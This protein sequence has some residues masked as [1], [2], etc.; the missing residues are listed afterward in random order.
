MRLFLPAVAVLSGAGGAVA[1]SALGALPSV[2]YAVACMTG[3]TAVAWWV[4]R[5]KRGRRALVVGGVIVSFAIHMV[6]LALIR[7]L[8]P[9]PSVV[10]RAIVVP[11]L[12][13]GAFAGM[14]LVVALAWLHQRA[15]RCLR[16]GEG[17]LV[18]RFELLSIVRCVAISC[19]VFMVLLRGLLPDA[20]HLFPRSL[21]V[22]SVVVGGGALA[23]LLGSLV[24]DVWWMRRALFIRGAWRAASPADPRRVAE[25]H[26][27]FGVGSGQRDVVVEARGTY[28]DQDRC[29][30]RFWGDADAFARHVGERIVVE[31]AL[32]VV[33]TMLAVVVH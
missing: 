7:E 11:S 27:Y 13:T 15:V 10:W 8:A 12:I 33:V 20:D 18:Q 19:L 2:F 28:R 30:V 17:S 4:E 21:F 25:S 26:V 5:G 1:G 9:A 3:F 32:S 22:V 24:N 16:W 6:V 31:T 23:V 14:P 29:I